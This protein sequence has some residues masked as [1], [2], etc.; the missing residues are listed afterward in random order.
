MATTVNLVQE[1]SGSKSQR[2]VGTS[3]ARGLRYFLVAVVRYVRAS[4]HLGI[5]LA[6]PG[7]I[8]SASSSRTN[9]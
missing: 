4:K 1:A 9:K 5:A 7:P 3:Q 8:F 6:Q 2:L